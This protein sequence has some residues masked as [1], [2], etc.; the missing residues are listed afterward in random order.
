[1]EATT[2]IKAFTKVVRPGATRDGGVFLKIEWDGKR[3]S[4]SGVVAP[5]H[6]GNCRG[7]CGQCI[8]ALS[9][10]TSYADGWDAASVAQL[11]A[12]WN[13]WHLNDMRAGCEHQRESWDVSEKIEVVEYKLTSEA[14][15]ERNALIA[16]AAIAHAGG[17][18][19][20]LTETGK[21]LVR[22]DDWFKPRY[23]P[24]EADSPLSGCYEVGKRETKAAGWVSPSEHPRGLLGK[25]CEVCGYKYGTSWLHE[26]VPADVL[27]WLR[28]LPVTD[29]TPAWV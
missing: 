18:P 9:E 27:E 7:S 8:G 26:E 4:I 2:A 16:A 17:K 28:S 10:L 21:A 20:E 22:L 12:F 24:P 6:G 3:L 1:M 5:M 14:Y 23:E 25:P 11:A 15:K 19:C 13:R 29:R